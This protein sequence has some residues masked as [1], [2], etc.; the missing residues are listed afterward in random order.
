MARWISA[1]PIGFEG[2]LNF[3]EYAANSPARYIDKN[4]LTIWVCVRD[5]KGAL[6]CIANHT[7][8][9]DDRNNS[10]CGA[11]SRPQRSEGGPT[12]DRCRPVEGTNGSEATI[13]FCC[14][15]IYTD[16]KYR[17]HTNDCFTCP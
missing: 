2:G 13:M 15:S 5:V 14:N 11:L 1:D 17:P 16:M 10:C 3:Y 9:W 4:G 6:G 7:Y 8:F 12:K